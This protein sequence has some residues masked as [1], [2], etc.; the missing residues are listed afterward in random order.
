MVLPSSLRKERIFLYLSN[1]FCFMLSMRRCRDCLTKD[2]RPK[3]RVTPVLI[4][5]GSTFKVLACH[6]ML[7]AGFSVILSLRVSRKTLFLFLLWP[8][9]LGDLFELLPSFFGMRHIVFSLTPMI[10][11]ISFWGVYVSKRFIIRLRFAS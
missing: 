5:L 4:V 6:L 10:L 7:T 3:F 9:L 8:P 2:L 1:L 11:A